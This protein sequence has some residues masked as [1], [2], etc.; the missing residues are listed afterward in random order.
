MSI[1]AALYERRII[2]RQRVLNFSPVRALTS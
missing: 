2:F 1:V